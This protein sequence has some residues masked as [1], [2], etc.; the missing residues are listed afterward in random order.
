MAEES[1]DQTI[2]RGRHHPYP[3]KAPKATPA[4]TPPPT[5]LA[6]NIHTRIAT[7]GPI[8]FRDYMEM[9]LYHPE[10]GYYSGGA[11]RVGKRG[12]FITSVSVGACFGTIFAHRLHTCWQEMGKPDTF[13][14]IEPG[15]HD[16]ALCAD[17]MGEIQRISAEFFNAITYH[18]IE[19]SPSL[20]H[21]QTRRLDTHSP[22]KCTPHASLDE[23]RGLTGALLSNELIDAFPVELLRFRDGKWHQQFVDDTTD[24]LAFTDRPPASPRLAKFCKQLGNAFPDGYTTEYN[25]ELETYTQDAA[26]A[27]A[28]GLFITIDYG[29]ESRD[30]YHPDRTRGTLQTYHRHQK[31]DDPLLYP[32]EIDITSHVDFT[33]LADAAT[34]AG[35]SNPILKTQSSYLTTHARDWLISMETQA[36]THTAPLLRQFQTLTHPS[37]LGSRFLVLE[38]AKP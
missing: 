11:Q 22:G 29:H 1:S 19:R 33:R 20:R 31:A 18:P 38:M 21:A 3:H 30:Y 23:L 8:S 6:E 26:S 34:A 14:I 13:H 7:N 4:F 2:P 5:A 35:F 16:G 15:A 17:I 37:M 25:P 32:G 27:L 28:K 36:P 10:H 24:G 9:A 12:D